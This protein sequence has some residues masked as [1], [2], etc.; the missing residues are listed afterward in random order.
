[1]LKHSIYLDFRV[2][3]MVYPQLR[4]HGQQ[5]GLQ[6]SESQFVYQVHLTIFDNNAASLI[7]SENNCCTEVVQQL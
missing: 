2:L 3:L 4:N 5:P 7:Y 6:W 1:M